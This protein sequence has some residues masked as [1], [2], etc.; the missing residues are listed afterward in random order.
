[1]TATELP[2]GAILALTL[3]LV[4][5]GLVNIALIWFM[6]KVTSRAQANEQRAMTTVLSLS[7]NS[8]AEKLAGYRAGK[9]GGL[10]DAQIRL[11]ENSSQPDRQEMAS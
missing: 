2:A 5:L 6:W 7:S 4:F 11:I 9:E 8:A 10:T 3:L 1:M